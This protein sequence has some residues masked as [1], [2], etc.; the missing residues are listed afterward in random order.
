[1]DY[2]SRTLLHRAALNGHARTVEQLLTLIEDQGKDGNTPLH[3]A[4][5][6]SH[7]DVVEL[8]LDKRAWIQVSNRFFNPSLHPAAWHG[9]KGMVA[10]L[11]KNSA[12]IDV[13][14]QY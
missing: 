11:L 5:W 2:N 14:N 3:L 4:G 6:K 10:L 1:M 13:R 8:L 9:H 7:T 12:L